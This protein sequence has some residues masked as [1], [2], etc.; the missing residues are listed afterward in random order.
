MPKL[1]LTLEGKPVREVDLTRERTTFGRH[2]QC[3]IVLDHRTVSARHALFHYANGSVVLED[4]GSTNGCFVNGKRVTRHLLADRDRVTLAAY[5]LEL[6]LKAGSARPPVMARVTV[7]SGPHAGKQL[8]LAKP[9]TTLGSAGA[10][11]VAITRQGDRYAVA[12]ID[13]PQPVRVNGE[14]IGKQPRP[15]QD[16][17]QIDL[18][19]N[20][21]AFSVVS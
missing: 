17:D 15:L 20:P 6:D 9:V 12:H 2:P 14:L 8:A 7:Q 10:A 13:G 19:G 1:L 5:H 18:A 4:L 16:G 21:M 3:D 11:V